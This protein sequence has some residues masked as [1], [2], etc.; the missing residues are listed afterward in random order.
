MSKIKRTLEKV[1]EVERSAKKFVRALRDWEEV[2]PFTSEKSQYYSLRNPSV[3][4]ILVA[5]AIFGHPKILVLFE[6]AEK[7]GPTLKDGG[8]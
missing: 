4:L 6:E 7:K 5:F 1:W 3:P 2:S 8:S